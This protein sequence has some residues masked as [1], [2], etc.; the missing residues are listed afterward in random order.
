V[1]LIHWRNVSED[2]P[3]MNHPG[4]VGIESV[5]SSDG[6]KGASAAESMVD[7]SSDWM[8]RPHG[9]RSWVAGV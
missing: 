7:K 6:A 1:R 8:R 2:Y 9:S 3:R 5:G 4:T